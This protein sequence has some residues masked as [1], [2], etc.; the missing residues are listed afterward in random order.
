MAETIDNHWLLKDK[1]AIHNSELTGQDGRGKPCVTSVT[2]SFV[3]TTLRQI[4]L[5]YVNNAMAVIFDFITDA[6]WRE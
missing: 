3:E 4:S 6:D 5:V 2:I 1:S